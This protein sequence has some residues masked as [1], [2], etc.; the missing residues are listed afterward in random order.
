MLIQWLQLPQPYFGNYMY[1]TLHANFNTLIKIE[2][3]PAGNNV[4]DLIL[5]NV[6]ANNKIILNTVV[7]V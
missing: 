6:I 3:K 7:H 5:S 2:K 1:F 4:R